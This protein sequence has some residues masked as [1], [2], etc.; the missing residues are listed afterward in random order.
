MTKLL[1]T[2]IL[3]AGLLAAA[4][5]P[6][7]FTG[8]VTDTMCGAKHT[9]GITPDA[10]CV[11]ECVK[12]DPSKWKY[13]ILVGNSVYV[14]SDQR[15]PEKFAAQ[16]VIVTGTLFEKTKVLEVDKI[17]AAISSG[18]HSGNSH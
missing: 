17:E 13:A 18:G 10:K 11:H 7:T 9:M 5:K 1:G 15:T 4:D 6:R 14:L 3:A 8:G 2:L 12:M 16:K